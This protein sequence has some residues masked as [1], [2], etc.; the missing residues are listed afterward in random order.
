[1]P[2]RVPTRIG[3]KESLCTWLIRKATTIIKVTQKKVIGNLSIKSKI[4]RLPI[5]N[6]QKI[7]S[8]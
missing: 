4:E 3:D 7:Y 8:L 2:I 1:M 6:R 5:T